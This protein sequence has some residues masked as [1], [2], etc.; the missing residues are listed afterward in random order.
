VVVSSS[1]KKTPSVSDLTIVNS[2]FKCICCQHLQQELETAL[3]ELKT[4]KK[5][6]EL[7]QEETKSTAPS[8][9]ANTQ[10]RNATCDLSALNRDIEK[11]MS[12][13]W[14]EVN[15]TRRKYNNQSDAQQRQ[16]IPIIVNRFTLPDNH[17]EESEASR[18]Q[19]W[20]RKQQLGKLKTNASQN[21]TE[22]KTLSLVT[23]TQEAV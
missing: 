5:I 4:A 1:E 16:P 6:T 2:D 10:C 22:I 7:L 12:G 19:V 18:F 9:T 23:A 21:H 20:L 3:L 13:T 14:K 11:N 8:T 17:Q 15:C